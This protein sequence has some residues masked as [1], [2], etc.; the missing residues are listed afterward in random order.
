MTFPRMSLLAI[1]I[2]L[3]LIMMESGLRLY[4]APRN[5][6]YVWPPGLQKILQPDSA[7]FP[8]VSGEARFFIN[9]DGIRGP[10]FST[11]DDYRILALGGST[12]ECV[13][14]DQGETW[15][16]ILASRLKTATP[17][18]N[19]WV[20]NLGASGKNMRDHLYHVRYLL[21]Q[22]KD[23]DHLIILSGLNDFL[24][25]L[26]RGDAYRGDFLSTA[27][28]KQHQY[29]QAFIFTPLPAWPFDG[30]RAFYKNTA[31]WQTARLARMQLLP[32]GTRGLYQ[33]PAGKYILAARALHGK[34][35]QV[36]SLPDIS[37]ALEEY[38]RNVHLLIDLLEKQNV[39]P[40]FLTHPFL[41]KPQMTE[42]E[43]SL[44]WMGWQKGADGQPVAFYTPSALA[45]G[46]QEYNE[47]L[48]A[49]CRER[50]VP[51]L[52]LA[53]HIPADISTFYDDVHFNESGARR[54]G[55]L[56]AD[57]FLNEES[58]FLKTARGAR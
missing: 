8:G 49:V 36:S 2:M 55:E 21:P 10:E 3:G 41:W 15:P 44:L 37:S 11:E 33:D 22:L 17:E 50:Q 51:V 4:L 5:G 31:I 24:L 12:T 27:A 35:R 43:R 29:Q 45:K 40:L 57:Y 1:G 25:R 7:I 13:Y 28:G 53:A 58:L 6:F 52:D 54:I 47:A 18:Q 16:D 38:Q 20:G 9:S 46:M 32:M 26:N 39:R 14:L 48:R 23:I 56:L 30:K 19:V 34:S 42:A